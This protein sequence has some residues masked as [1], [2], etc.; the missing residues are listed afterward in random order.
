MLTNRGYV[1]NEELRAIRARAPMVTVRD[2]GGAK[3][4]GVFACREIP[5]DTYFTA[6]PC[7]AIAFIKEDECGWEYIP[8]PAGDAQEED[9]EKGWQEYAGSLP[10]TNQW[11]EPVRLIGH[12]GMH[13]HWACG[14]MINDSLTLE[15]AGSER[16]YLRQRRGN[17]KPVMMMMDGCMLMQTTKR[18]KIGQELFYNYGVG[19]WKRQQRLYAS[20]S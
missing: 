3:G 5:A 2:A 14:H 4:M 10:I 17:C 9:F 6:Y 19:Y 11:G 1:Q 16:A 13:Q 7:A 12:P 18:V 15:Q 20:R 8:S